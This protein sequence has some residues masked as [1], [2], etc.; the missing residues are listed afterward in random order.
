MQ[1]PQRMRNV[2]KE[3]FV[4]RKPCMGELIQPGANDEGVSPRVK[5]NPKHR[6]IHARCS[7]VKSRI[8]RNGVCIHPRIP[9][10]F[11]ERN[12]GSPG[13]SEYGNR[14]WNEKMETFRG[15][16]RQSEAEFP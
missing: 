6:S 4:K 8:D 5:S 9:Q 2:H 1:N 15:R 10:P 16:M 7:V 14:V 3:F 13:W 11:W 12:I